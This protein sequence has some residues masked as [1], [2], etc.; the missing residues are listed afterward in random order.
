METIGRGPA[1]ARRRTGDQHHL[2]HRPPLLLPSGCPLPALWSGPMVGQ[3][4]QRTAE[5]G[6]PKKTSDGGSCAVKNDPVWQPCEMSTTADFG[7][8]RANATT[9]GWN[10][11]SR[12][13]AMRTGVSANDAALVTASSDAKSAADAYAPALAPVASAYVVHTAGLMAAAAVN[14]S[15]YF[16][17]SSS[18]PYP[19][20]EMPIVPMRCGARPRFS[21]WQI[22]TSSPTTICIGSSCGCGFQ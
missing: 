14:T 8:A 2:R 10:G 11:S 17:A 19:P 4:A 1:D 20:I 22:G 3:R 18:A 15:G 13:D 21:A 6:A 12:P 9:P 7:N 5:R 16:S